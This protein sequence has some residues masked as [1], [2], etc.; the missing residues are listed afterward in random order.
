MTLLSRSQ[1]RHSCRPSQRRS[2]T[3]PFE[4][5][6]PRIAL[7]A[8]AVTHT[9][10]L[11]VL[12]PQIQV[13][14]FGQ[15]IPFVDGVLSG[16]TLSGREKFQRWAA[17]YVSFITNSGVSVASINIG[18]Y[19]TDTKGYYAYLDPALGDTVN[20]SKVPWIITDFLDKLPAGVEAG[21]IAYLDVADPWKLY[22]NGEDAA[23]HATPSQNFAGN[24]L[25]TDGKAGSPPKNN[26]YQAF[27]LINRINATQ[28]AAGGS[29]LITHFEADGEGAGAF[30]TDTY[31]GF[32]GPGSGAFKKDTPHQTAPNP[33]WSWNAADP[34]KT[35]WP[36]AGYGYTKWLFNHFMPGVSATAAAAADGSTALPT[37]PKQSVVFSDTDA[38]NPSF[39][40]SGTQPGYQFGIIKYAQTAWLEYSPGPM[41]AFTENYWF[42]ENHYLPGPG[43]AV[44]ATET[45]AL[46]GVNRPALPAP[47][48]TLTFTS[49]PQVTFNTPVDASGNPI[50]TAAQGIAIMGS[51]AIDTSLDPHPFFG[52]GRG[53]GYSPGA[54]VTSGG[55]GYTQGNKYNLNAVF[56]APPAGPGHR[57]AT[58]FVNVDASGAITGIVVLDPGAGY[59]DEPTITFTGPGTG[60]QA[61]ALVTAASG[62]PQITFPEP[63]AGGAKPQAYLTVNPQGYRAGEITGIVYLTDAAGKPL[64]GRGYDYAPISGNSPTQ[65]GGQFAGPAGLEATFST[66][67]APPEVLAKILPSGATFTPPPSIYLPVNSA[68]N[69]IDQI[70][71]TVLGDHYAEDATKPA[72]DPANRNRPY[73]TLA[74]DPAETKHFVDIDPNYNGA[75]VSPFNRAGSFPVDGAG[76]SSIEILDGGSGYSAGVLLTDGGEGYDSQTTYL[77]TFS[78]G[79]SPTRHAT[80]VLQINSNGQA[81]GVIITDPGEG[82]TSEPT[83]SIPT[84]SGGTAATGTVHLLNYPRVTLQGGSFLP[85]GG[86]PAEPFVITGPANRK[87]PGNP[88]TDYVV[89]GIGF[90][91]PGLGYDGS[92][93]APTFTISGGAAGNRQATALALPAL[94]N[95]TTANEL[96]TIA[97]IL[98]TLPADWNGEIQGG[99]NAYNWKVPNGFGPGQVTGVTVSPGAGYTSAPTVSFSA[100]RPGGRQATGTAVLGTGHLAGT[101]VAITVTD[102]GFGYGEPPTITLAGGGAT[103]AASAT[104]TLGEIEVPS[105]RALETVYAYYQDHP[106]ALA[107]MFDNDHYVDVSLPKLS[108]EF[109]WPLDWA[110]FG[111]PDATDG[112]KTPQQAIATFS[113]ESINRSN[114]FVDGVYQPGTIQR[115]SLDSKYQPADALLPYNSYGGTFSGLSSLTYDN[116]VAFLNEAATII[117]DAATAGGATMSP[118]DVTFQL[119]DVAFLPTEW[120][121]EQN[122]RRWVTT[123]VARPQLHPVTTL[124]VNHAVIG[125]SPIAFGHAALGSVGGAISIPASGALLNAWL[126]K[127]DKP[128]GDV[129]P[130]IFA[131]VGQGT[132]RVEK[133]DGSGWVDVS[134]PAPSVHPL[135]LL[136]KLATRTIQQGDRLRWVPPENP[137]REPV[138]FEIIAWDGNLFSE[139][140]SEVH[141]VGSDG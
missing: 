106:K 6:E 62:Y 112:T 26:L 133:W 61:V 105:S 59:A 93:P 49:P 10:G 140:T 35:D 15:D 84:P 66:T 40:A 123:T 134:T 126:P 33:S 108:E 60:G 21:A 1:P 9:N 20:G 56:S 88:D 138:A 137:G 116:F 92:K 86:T 111:T 64:A 109:Y 99:A 7:S 130:V 113:L 114:A 73:Y 50:G 91:F 51:G 127:L 16:E 28:L 36:V 72:S 12:L 115:T 118:E 69:R 94:A 70:L 17:D 30:E 95:I 96:Q 128:D 54:W 52:S 47:D 41:V 82:Y 53:A 77:L 117:A 103:T 110:S 78:G 45:L 75:Y 97:Q 3:S 135:H 23:G 122:S 121:A 55:S 125:P 22:G 57:T 98:G 81:T 104:A 71:L 100:P 120:L 32:G 63:P 5:L 68:A 131:I 27:E 34:L 107:A 44:L 132:G 43:S 14:H 101:V 83:V 136:D 19:T 102:P 87:D 76:R 4:Q 18:D 90:R 38:T 139:N 46:D 74:G 37:T 39:W 24:N 11:P 58:G 119:Y 48:T 141:F 65:P 124:T 129:F 29:K 85:G 42:G 89:T 80:G 8:T 2:S 79:G 13:S 25:T 67:A 31:Y